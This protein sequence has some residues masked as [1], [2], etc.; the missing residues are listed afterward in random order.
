VKL[1]LGVE[2]LQAGDWQEEAAGA[3]GAAGAAAAAGPEGGA[4]TDLEVPT[5]LHTVQQQLSKKP[6]RANLTPLFEGLPSSIQEVILTG[7]SLCK[8]TLDLRSLQHLSNLRQLQLPEYVVFEGPG[9]DLAALTALTQLRGD[10][11]LSAGSEP[12]LRVPNL[13]RLV[14]PT[15]AM[16]AAGPL[17]ALAQQQQLRELELAFHDASVLPRYEGEWEGMNAAEAAWEGL[18]ATLPKL[19]QLT[20][21][22]LTLK[23]ET[24][25]MPPSVEE[26][27]AAIKQLVNLRTLCMP[28]EFMLAEQTFNPLPEGLTALTLTLGSGVYVE[29]LLMELDPELLLPALAVLSVSD[30]SALKSV[31]FRPWSGSGE[32]PS[33]EQYDELQQGSQALPPEVKVLWGGTPLQQVVPLPAPPVPEAAA[34]AAA[35]GGAEGAA[36]GA[37]Q[38]EDAAAPAAGAAAQPGVAAAAG[39]APAAV[40]GEAAAA[41]PAGGD[42]VPMA[43][44]D[45]G[46]A[47]DA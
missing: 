13:R 18:E 12:L 33:Q 29:E 16:A 26:P 47:A 34:A 10:D 44:Q 36:A 28:V 27:A 20:S 21:L 23:P 3:T 41:A 2:G 24:A 22:S 40:V 39:E 46:G 6:N 17:A 11:A 35:G 5:F 45:Q 15:A 8:C 37:G 38:A 19:Q 9:A 25:D 43:E 4:G 14:V 7:D 1:E 31:D 42:D 32:P 30:V